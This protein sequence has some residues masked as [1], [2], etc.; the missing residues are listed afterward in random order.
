MSDKIKF[1]L[2]Y[3]NFYKANLHSYSNLSDG[4]LSPEE[5]KNIYKKAGYSVLAITDKKPVSEKA[6]CDKDFL[7]LSGFSFG[8]SSKD[9]YPIKNP[10]FTAISLNEAPS[11]IDEF[12][13]KYDLEAIRDYISE[14]KKKG[15]FTTFCSPARSC[16]VMPE[17]LN[18]SE[19]DAMEI[20]NYS[21]LMQGYDEYSAVAYDNFVRRNHRL[22]A[23]AN[24]GNKNA[25]PLDSKKSDSFGAFTYINSDSLDYPSIANSLKNGHFYASEG[26]EI[27]ALWIKGDTLNI[28]TSPA[29]KIVVYS[30]RRG[31][32][33]IFSNGGVPLT[34][35]SFKIM[36]N[37]VCIRCIVTDS[38]GNRAFTRSYYIDEIM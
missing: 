33:F 28:R 10:L 29:D 20:M 15:Y 2:P 26:P 23:M 35:A 19:A 37:E 24:D 17:Y 1:L 16:L 21:S 34:A 36:P 8:A 4:A 18:F 27:K 9:T 31:S 13:G 30:G 5:L 3:K 38:D 14:C 25:L 11:D 7:T 32:K 12:S 22:F 6:L